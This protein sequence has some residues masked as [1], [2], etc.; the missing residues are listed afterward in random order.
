MKT[1]PRPASERVSWCLETSSILTPFLGRVSVPSS[2][3][4]LFI[5]YILSYLLWKA[6]GYFSGHLMSSAS[7]QK[8][9]C[10]V[11][12]AFKCS[13]DEFVGE[14]VVSPSYSSAIFTPPLHWFFEYL[15]THFCCWKTGQFKLYDMAILVF[16]LLPLTCGF[17]VVLLVVVF[18]CLVAILN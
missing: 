17:S 9:F 10:G 3:V 11:C 15:I 14:K 4:S 2:F 16:R 12:L 18:I 7:D 5:F 8:L 1:S 13:F 6:M